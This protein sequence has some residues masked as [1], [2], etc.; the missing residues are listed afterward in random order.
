[1]MKLNNELLEKYNIPVP[2]YTSYPPANHFNENFSQE[3]YIEL[4]KKSNSQ[5]PSNIAFYIHI[6]F[7][8]KICHYCGCNSILKAKGDLVKPYIVSLKKEI[9]IISQWIDK[10]RLVTQIHYGGGTPNSILAD[11]ISEINNILYSKFNFIDSPEIAIETNPAHLDFDYI[12]KLKQTGFN[13]FSLGI[14]DFDDNI[15]KTVNREPSKLPV[16]ELVNYIK[17]N[18][19][20]IAINLDF[21]YGLPG[22]TVS[23]FAQ[24]IKK[25]LEIKPDRLVTFSYA[26]I[27]WLKKYQSV[28]EKNGLPNAK[29]K[30][31]MF[32]EAFN[33]L[34]SAGYKS[35][36]MDHYVLP[37][38]ELN[39]ALMNNQLHRNFQGYCSRRTTGQ[40]YAFGVSSI[41]Q[42]TSGYSQNTKDITNYIN[43]LEKNIL[44]VDK[45]Y[46]L[47][48]N[49]III[50]EVITNLMCNKN[51]IWSDI[52]TLFNMSVIELKNIIN[53][54]ES[55]L[56]E[57]IKDDLI[58]LDN[59][60]IHITENGSI[61]IRNIAAALDPNFKQELNKYS[62]SV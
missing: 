45:G 38:D 56:T 6:P 59:K 19:K 7:C 33:L 55:K 26:H 20:N 24:T 35:I 17:S 42:L 62:K 50:K 28:L 40:V 10:K 2:R 25:A 9:E 14:Q 1:M 61:F 34:T 41:S 48:Q 13:R 58:I 4:I 16:K 30:M 3:N 29:D 8:D 44:P 22:Q 52:A 32:L 27:P 54:D 15:L 39:I 12:D 46:L 60:S 31:G 37:E 5:E 36:G 47:S 18:N 53:F 49:E 57:F 43:S 23:S 21:I 11:Y 51:I